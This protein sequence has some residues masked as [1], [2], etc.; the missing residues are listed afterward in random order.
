MTRSAL[1]AVRGFHGVEVREVEEDE[2]L[3][4]VRGDAVAATD[5]EPVEQGVASLPP[6]R[7]LPGRSRRPSSSDR[8]ELGAREHVEELR[9]AGASRAGERNH[10]RLDAEAES[11]SRLLDH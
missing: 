11:G 6:D 3:E 10:R 1:E 2:P 4:A 5:L 7:G 8:R 9:L